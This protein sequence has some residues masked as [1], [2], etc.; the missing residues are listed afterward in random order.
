MGP[1]GQPPIA[2]D[3][4]MAPLI[5]LPSLLRTE[6][7][8]AQVLGRSRAIL[9]VPDPARALVFAGLSTLS[10]RRPIVAA[11]PTTADAERLA[12]DLSSYLGD[13]AVALFP[14]WET[15]PFERV[16]PGV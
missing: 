15:L 9:A 6:P 3:G 5:D 16:S 4:L 13:D 10:K 14:A 2:S 12:H 11:M 7:A 1:G 8:L